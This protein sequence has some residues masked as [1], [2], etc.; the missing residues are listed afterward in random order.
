MT[1]SL[2][3][4]SSPSAPGRGGAFPPRGR[5]G[6]SA[7]YKK[8]VPTAAPVAMSSPPVLLRNSKHSYDIDA[9]SQAQSTPEFIPSMHYNPQGALGCAAPPPCLCLPRLQTQHK[10]ALTLSVMCAV[11]L[12]FIPPS[13]PWL[14]PI[15]APPLLILDTRNA[16][17]A[18]PLHP[19]SLSHP[20]CDLRPP[21]NLGTR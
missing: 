2:S 9:R 18:S 1:R 8:V 21:F 4:F 16:A 15:R 17:A 20:S 7:S 14:L 19:L 13:Q 5:G 12:P 3:R 6:H 10:P 11:F